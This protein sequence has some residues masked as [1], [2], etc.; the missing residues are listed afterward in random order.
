MNDSKSA[1]LSVSNYGPMN[2]VM[3]GIVF[4]LSKGFIENDI[5]NLIAILIAISTG[6]LFYRLKRILRIKNSLAAG[7]VSFVI[8]YLGSA[9]LVSASITVFHRLLGV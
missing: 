1:E 3:T 2:Y 4:A 9:F 8:L 6:I 5:D 7:F